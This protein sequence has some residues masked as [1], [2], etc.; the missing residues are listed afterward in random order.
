MKH[1]AIPASSSPALTLPPLNLKP[2]PE[3]S[4]ETR[5]FQGIPTLERAPNGR[6]WAAWYGG[7][8]DE[9]EHNSVFLSTSGDDGRSWQRVLVLDPDGAGP[10]RAFDP[11]LWHAPDGKL[12]LFWSQET[13]G[14]N[15]TKEVLAITTTESG[16]GEPAWSAPRQLC[17]G[18]MMNKPTV[19][20]GG[21]WLLPVAT[22]SANG[23]SRVVASSDNG[24][25]FNELGSANIRDPKIRNYDEHMIIER[26]DGTLWMLV[27]TNYGIGESLSTDGGRTWLDVTPSLIPHPVSRFFIRRLASNRLLLVRHNP[28]NN[29]VMRS[30]LTAFLS[31]DD[32]RS[33]KGGLLLDERV[34]VS[35]PDGAQASDGSIRVIYDYQRKTDK[36]ILIAAFTEADVLECGIISPNSRL[37]VLVNKATGTNPSILMQP[38]S[39]FNTGGGAMPT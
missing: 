25:T 29:G 16:I 6:L 18:V 37:R 15:A 36:E 2:G 28:P 27:R 39:N 32:G 4:D 34:W 21:E 1:P 33:W 19:V 3:Y 24:T 26:K 31:D 14:Q 12:W 35:Y 7:G 20:A 38:D 8:I 9:D 11:C 10:L 17:K 5:M 22:W 23:S 30:H 13:Q